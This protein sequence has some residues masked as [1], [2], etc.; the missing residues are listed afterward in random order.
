MGKKINPIEARKESDSQCV[1]VQYELNL[2]VHT[3]RTILKGALQVLILTLYMR[4]YGLLSVETVCYNSAVAN[5][6]LI[7][8]LPIKP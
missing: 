8:N 1:Q 5:E 2:F 6:S 4:R 7:R 3:N